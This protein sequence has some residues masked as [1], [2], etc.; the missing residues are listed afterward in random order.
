MTTTYYDTLRSL[1]RNHNIPCDEYTDEQLGAYIDEA[2]L[3]LNTPYS[4]DT[5]FTDYHDHFHGRVYLT[6]YYPL[7][8]T[9]DVVVKVDD[10][11]VTPRRITNDGRVFLEKCVDGSLECTYTVGLSDDDIINTILPVTMYIIQASNGT[12]DISSVNEGDLSVSYD[13]S[14]GYNAE[15]NKLVQQLKNKYRARVRII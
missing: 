12:G 1:L 15:V 7:L 2:K 5:T 11:V 4:F 6:D 10:I 3:L 14:N 13:T 8:S 9:S